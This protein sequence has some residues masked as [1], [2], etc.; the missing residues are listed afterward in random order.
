MARI[1]VALR[2]SDYTTAQIV[3]WQDS[4]IDLPVRWIKAR[5]LHVTL[6]PPWEESEEGIT[7]VKKQL[8]HGQGHYGSFDLT[9]NTVSYG[10]PLASPRLIWAEGSAPASLTEM[11]R[12]LHMGLHQLS[13]GNMVKVHC[14]IARFNEEDFKNFP[15]KELYEPVEWRE[16]VSSLVLMQSELRPTGAEYTVLHEVAL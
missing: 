5:N 7:T 6:V 8:D 12:D 1:F 9:F 3:R 14:T 13:K 11:V 2:L 10:P 4:H 15:I 16:T